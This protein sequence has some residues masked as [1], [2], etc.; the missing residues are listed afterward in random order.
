MRTVLLLAGRPCHAAVP[1]LLLLAPPALAKDFSNAVPPDRAAWVK[2]R[3]DKEAHA[4]IRELIKAVNIER[5]TKHL[6]HLSKDPLPLTDSEG[7][8]ALNGE[9][10]STSRVGLFRHSHNV[11]VLPEVWIRVTALGYRPALVRLDTFTGS[12]VDW[13]D[14]PFDT[15]TIR[16]EKR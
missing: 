4:A 6:F 13:N 14:L 1:A 15:M 9:F 16:L 3:K 11:H 8:V 7:R 10:R 5:M 12:R 2:V